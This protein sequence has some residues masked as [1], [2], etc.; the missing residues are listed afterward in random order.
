[1]GRGIAEGL[2]VWTVSYF[3]WVPAANILRRASTHPFRR[4]ALMIGAHVVWGACNA[5]V[6]R[7]LERSRGSVL[8]D[9]PLLD[10][11]A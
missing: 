6:S 11:P 9:G 10:R 5:I 2:A 3:G 4:T 7:E 1:M 8:V